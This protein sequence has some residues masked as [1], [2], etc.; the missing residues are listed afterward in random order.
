M[1]S[2]IGWDGDVTVTV[3]A[4]SRKSYKFDI[5]RR[6]LRFKVRF[7]G[8]KYEEKKYKSRN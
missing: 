4:P 5:N 6:S 1:N 7:I 3:T 8:D 2:T